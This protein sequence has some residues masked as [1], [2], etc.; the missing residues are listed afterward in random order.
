MFILVFLCENGSIQ[1]IFVRCISKGAASR[2]PSIYRLNFNI[3][4]DP[5]GLGLRGFKCLQYGGK[6][7]LLD[8]VRV[9]AACAPR[10]AHQRSQRAGPERGRWFAA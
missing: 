10:L 6:H 8:V 9:A 5:F 2:L 1:D 4:L 3:E 7:Q